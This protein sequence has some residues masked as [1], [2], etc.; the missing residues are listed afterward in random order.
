MG[1]PRPSPTAPPGSARALLGLRKQ[2]LLAGNHRP[3]VTGAKIKLSA[4]SSSY[5]PPK[6]WQDGA[7]AR[8]WGKLECPQV[9]SLPPTPLHCQNQ[10]S[11]PRPH[12]HPPPSTLPRQGWLLR[13]RG[14]AASRAERKEALSSSL[15]CARSTSVLS[16]RLHA[17]PLLSH[18]LSCQGHHQRERGSRCPDKASTTSVTRCHRGPKTSG[19]SLTLEIPGSAT[20]WLWGWV[21][22]RLS[23]SLPPRLYI[24]VNWGN[25]DNSF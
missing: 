21:S 23:E 5:L 18:H 22:P 14:P 9:Q 25:E 7:L 4:D 1:P 8:A 20:S 10:T 2:E 13:P 11:I 17:P 24:G 6:T 16:W 3:P 19:E 15:A 12:L